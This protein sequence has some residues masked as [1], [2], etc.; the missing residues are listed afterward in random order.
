MLTQLF[1]GQTDIENFHMGYE[2]NV[3]E[4]SIKFLYKLTPHR[5]KQSFGI[6]VA[7]LTGL[8]ENV[9]E[10]AKAKSNELYLKLKSLT[11]EIKLIDDKAF[12]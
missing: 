12:N 6:Q 7:R 9:L 2:E 4:R 10:I 1:D 5:W 3:E 11:K 8:P